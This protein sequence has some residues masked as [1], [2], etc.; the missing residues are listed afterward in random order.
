MK[1]KFLPHHAILIVLTV[2]IGISCYE[3]RA[4]Y[5]LDHPPPHYVNC[6]SCHSDEKTI[7]AMKDKAG[8]DGVLVFSA[9]HKDVP[10]YFKE[11]QVSASKEL[12]KTTNKTK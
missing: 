2:V 1:Q 5:V 8:N 12:Q 10:E 4:L 9:Y 3:G 7:Q 6:I 11:R